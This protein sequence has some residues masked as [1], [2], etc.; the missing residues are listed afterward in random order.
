MVEMCV[1]LSY[2]FFLLNF[3]F[4][5]SCKSSKIFLKKK[6]FVKKNNN[7]YFFIIQCVMLQNGWRCT[8]ISIFANIFYEKK[9]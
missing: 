7:I 6:Y 5:L 3:P 1:S 9:I 8:C 4:I 2:V